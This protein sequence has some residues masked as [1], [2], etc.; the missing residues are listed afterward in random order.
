MEEESKNKSQGHSANQIHLLLEE[1]Q[2]VGEKKKAFN[3]RDKDQKEMQIYIE[4]HISPKLS[5]LD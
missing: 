1:M 5:F 3:N 2:Y 4:K